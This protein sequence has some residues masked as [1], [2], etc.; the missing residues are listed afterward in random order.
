M[1]VG[2]AGCAGYGAAGAT[3]S[4]A[5]ATGQRAVAGQSAVRTFTFVY[6]GSGFVQVA[7]HVDNRPGHAGS[8]FDDTYTEKVKWSISW[9]ITIDNGQLGPI[10]VPTAEVTGTASAEFPA[11]GGTPSCSGPVT[12]PVA[13]GKPYIRE[14]FNVI[15]TTQ[16]FITVRIEGFP[17]QWADSP[18][19]PSGADVP[20]N[21]QTTGSPAATAWVNSWGQPEFKIALLNN[22]RITPFSVG[23]TFPFAPVGINT[24][25]I[26]NWNA[27]LTIAGFAPK[28]P[29]PTQ[30]LKA[31]P[32]QPCTPTTGQPTPLTPSIASDYLNS[33][34]SYIERFG[35]A[36]QDKARA[37]DNFNAA[38]RNLHYDGCTKEWY[39]GSPWEHLQNRLPPPPPR[40][41]EDT[42]SGVDITSSPDVL[43]AQSPGKPSAPNSTTIGFTS[44]GIAALSSGKPLTVTLTGTFRV[45]GKP[46]ITASTKITL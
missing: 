4:G 17:L 36:L 40:P 41:N 8:A 27:R 29:P 1:V 7:Q 19:C 30:P 10:G 3:A 16:Q 14:N 24:K 39:V 31:P 44:A 21:V 5:A 32:K 23:N 20:G 2:V 37:I 35:D 13:N 15:N 22:Y 46:P 6:A 45:K 34:G 33:F 28:V 18:S 38:L 26:F 25:V 11:P 42:S 9:P 43:S 12:L